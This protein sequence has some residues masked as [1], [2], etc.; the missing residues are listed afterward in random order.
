LRNGRGHH[1]TR[2]ERRARRP[3]RGAVSECRTS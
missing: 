3:G 2:A 1:R